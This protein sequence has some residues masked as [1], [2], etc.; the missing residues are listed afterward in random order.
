[1]HG[2]AGDPEG[3]L[4]RPGVGDGRLLGRL[5]VAGEG[6]GREHDRGV[7]PSGQAQESL[8]AGKG[9]EQ[10]G[11]HP[12]PLAPLTGEQERHL[13]GG[14]RCG[15]V[16]VGQEHAGGGGTG[17]NAVELGRQVV[18]VV[19]DHGR[20]HRAG[21]RPAATDGH[22]EGE[23]AQRPRAAGPVVGRHELGQAVDVGRPP[24]EEQLGR[25]LLQAVGRLGR[26]VVAGQDGVEVGA[27]E[28]E[29]AHAGVALTGRRRPRTGAGR[30]LEGA[31]GR[32]P[33]GVGLGEVERPR[34]DP[35][36]QGQGGLD[37][38]GQPRRALGVPDLRLH[39]AEDGR[40]GCGPRGHEHLG[41]GGQLGAVADHGAGAVGLDQSDLGGRDPGHAVGPVEGGPLAFG[42][43]G[44]QAQ[45][46]PVA[47][48][49]D[50]LDHG[51][52]PVAV[53][54]GVLQRLRTTQ[55]TPS[56]RAIPSA[57]PSK[58]A[59]RPVGDRAWTEAN[60]R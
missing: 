28:A 3:G 48:P 39:R 31:R 5:V 36:V 59:H 29:G 14:G 13:P 22:G 53:A 18:E 32:V 17:P 15:G 51:V 6:Q 38:P 49:G 57:S 19:G 42:A 12:R 9:D 60:M 16:G 23:V 8:Q 35:G 26:P 41:E 1:M 2:Q 55:A 50:R 20:H 25:P 11:Q 34:T 10:V 7:A 46:L 27:A 30:E 43:G 4:G 52:D 54:L 47:R 37:Q 24:E 21:H 45:R 33:V 40:A 58:V 44:G 56:P